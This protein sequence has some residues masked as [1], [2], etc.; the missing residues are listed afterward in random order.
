MKRLLFSLLIVFHCVFSS[1]AQNT[2]SIFSLS[3]CIDLALRNNQ[4]IKK[5]SLQSQVA[6]AVRQEAFTKY[7]PNIGA[8]GFAFTTNHSVL[9]YT[10][11]EAI[12]VPPVPDIL[13]D[14]ADINVEMDFRL[15]KKGV[16]AG[17]NLV[18]PVFTGGQIY[19]G[20]K[21][22]ELGEAVAELQSRQSEDQVVITVSQYFW[23]LASLKSKLGTVNDVINLLDTLENQVSLAVKEG[24]TLRN[25]LLEVQLKKNE[26]LTDRME[27]ENG[28]SIVSILL[29]QYIGQGLNP[30][31]IDS[32]MNDS[33]KVES[34]ADIY[35]N[36]SS[37]LSE[38]TDYKLL[39]QNIKASEL[40]QK[41]ALGRN[42]PTVAVGAGYFY[43]DLFNQGHGFGSLYATVIIPIS[44]WWG[45]MHSVKQ[46]KLKTE[47]ART[48]MADYSELLQV[49]MKNAWDDMN[50]AYEKIKVAKLSI[51][52]AA[53]NLQLNQNYY[54]VGTITITDLLKAQTLYRQAR[55]KFI[56]AY[57][58]YQVKRTEYLVATG[59]R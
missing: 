14:G 46:A 42:L 12:P 21:L 19:H 41:M 53:D 2:D 45:G 22:A 52:Q 23:Q 27:L 16:M 1:F 54:K 17:V 9:G 36:T 24:V 43:S 48:E 6:K 3:Q 31:E 29:A 30:I 49:K 56:D 32:E 34:P 50:T 7:F 47:I 33:T 20:N 51:E 4:S 26:M 13:P 44:D 39:Q 8:T 11:K 58:N 35:V 57:G 38:T 37:A 28:I 40:E 55:D 5:A 25:E 59:R 15:I 10:F 18:Q